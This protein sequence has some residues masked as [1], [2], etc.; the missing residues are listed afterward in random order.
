MVDLDTFPL[1]IRYAIFKWPNGYFTKGPYRKPP[2]NLVMKLD[3][4]SKDE[5]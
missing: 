1:K 5:K 3:D 2:R 4:E